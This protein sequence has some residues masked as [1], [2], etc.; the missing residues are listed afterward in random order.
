[1]L[2]RTTHMQFVIKHPKTEFEAAKVVHALQI[3]K[4]SFCCLF[5]FWLS[6]AN[7]CS[8]SL[9]T[10]ARLAPGSEIANNVYTDVQRG[11]ETKVKPKPNTPTCI[12]QSIWCFG[13][14][15][16][17]PAGFGRSCKNI[18]KMN[19]FIFYLFQAKKLRT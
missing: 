8:W 17:M 1:M 12:W 13:Q 7:I 2:G 5:V 9:S 18:M 10:E 16:G 19:S 4:H 15:C 11:I 14:N 6:V 3:Y